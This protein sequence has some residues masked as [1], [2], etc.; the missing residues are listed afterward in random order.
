[1]EGTRT[2]AACLGDFDNSG[3][4]PTVQDIFEF[5]TAYFSNDARADINNSGGNPTSQ[6][7]F[8]FLNAYFVGCP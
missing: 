3:G 5:L 6:D 2:G 1:M 4:Q 8:D 7:I